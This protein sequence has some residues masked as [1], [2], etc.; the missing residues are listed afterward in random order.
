M[1]T[2]LRGSGALVRLLLEVMPPSPGAG[3]AVDWSAVTAAWGHGFPEDYREF[4]RCY[5]EGAVEDFL[6]LLIPDTRFALDS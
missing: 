1:W 5:G 6:A 4:V 2:G 3:D